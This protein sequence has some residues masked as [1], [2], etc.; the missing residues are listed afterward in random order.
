MQQSGFVC[1]ITCPLLFVTGS[2]CLESTM[3]RF[4][5]LPIFNPHLAHCQTEFF[6]LHYGFNTEEAT[7]FEEYETDIQHQ[8]VHCGTEVSWLQFAM[9]KEIEFFD[10]CKGH[11]K[12]EQN[13]SLSVNSRI[14]C[15]SHIIS[16][17]HF[18]L[19]Y[20]KKIKKEPLYFL[21]QS[22]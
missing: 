9:V 21:Y 16:H 11:M 12:V 7:V 1:A 3:Y 13:T 10:W 20:I 19:Q 8:L 18:M 2:F 6:L 17:C 4:W 14:R 5:I 15:T 22:L